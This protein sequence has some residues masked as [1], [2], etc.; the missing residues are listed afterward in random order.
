MKKF[1]NEH[2]NHN[3]DLKTFQNYPE[4]KK[5]SNEE[6]NIARIMLKVGA[7]KQKLQSHLI[8]NRGPNS[9]AI[10]LKGLH[11]LQ[12]KTRK[13]ETGKSEIEM[14][15][16]E[17]KKITDAK[18]KMAV[19]DQNELISIYFQ[20]KRMEQIFNLYPEI[21]LVDATYKL[22]NRRMPLF[23][24]LVMD[25]NGQSEIACFFILKAESQEAL[26]PM[27]TYFKEE[28]EKWNE[29]KVILSDKDFAERKIFKDKFPKAEMQICLFHIIKNFEREITTKKR[30]ITECERNQSITIIKDMIYADSESSYMY[31]YDELQKLSL[32]SV[33][34]YFD[35]NWHDIR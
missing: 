1:I 35:E 17:M 5:L 24:I 31:Y 4:S 20:D 9:S 26:E 8:E 23:L 13:T 34:K 18:I 10:S 2:S 29:T 14:L 30:N 33:L 15:L 11:N 27:I 22:N 12:S 25:G 28:N 7:N 6:E 32:P 16:E 3:C 19:N 21:M